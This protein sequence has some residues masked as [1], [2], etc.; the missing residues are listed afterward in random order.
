MT[1]LSIIT[2]SN[3]IFAKTLPWSF[4]VANA[5]VFSIIRMQSRTKRNISM[6]TTD[7]NYSVPFRRT[8]KYPESTVNYWLY[9][10]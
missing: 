8:D 7:L 6:D 5:F 2:Y 10:H 1:L 3:D 9:G 4:H